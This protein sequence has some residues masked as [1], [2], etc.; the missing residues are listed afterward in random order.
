VARPVPH[1][2]P[3]E[4]RS[5]VSPRVSPLG[6][7][8]H[9]T[10]SIWIDQQVPSKGGENPCLEGTR[11]GSMM[12]L[13]VWWYI[14]QLAQLYRFERRD[15][16]RGTGCQS[17]RN[18]W[19]IRAHLSQVCPCQSRAADGR[20]LNRWCLNEEFP[21]AT[22]AIDHESAIGE[23]TWMIREIGGE[24][25]CQSPGPLSPAARPNK[26]KNMDFN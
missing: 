14:E 18:G 25:I 26:K 2:I 3:W 22:R 20:T 13:V 7:C 12:R 15:A 23:R 16:W 24:V 4:S 19:G 6:F 9:K 17:N 21:L 1:R 10:D 8:L 11:R 5:W